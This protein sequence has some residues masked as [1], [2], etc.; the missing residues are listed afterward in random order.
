MPEVT[1][2]RI[3]PRFVERIWGTTQLAPWFENA[4]RRIGEVWFQTDPPLSLLTKFI[5]TSERLSVQ[6]HPND[7]QARA[8]GLD[9][10]KTEM[11]HILHAEPG[12]TVAL[13]FHEPVTLD[14]VEA[15]ART[16]AIEGM[17][18]WVSV[19]AGDT[20]YTPAGTVH[21]LGAGL[22]VV[23]VQQNSDTT[24]R[25][26]DYNRGRE[27]HLADGLAV[28]DLGP[29]RF[30][31]TQPAPAQDSAVTELVASDYFVTEALTL[32]AEYAQPAVES[33]YRLLIIL[34]GNGHIGQ[35][36]YRAGEVW[37]LNQGAEECRI[38][39]SGRTRILRTGPPVAG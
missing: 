22:V 38:V 33:G 26:W 13:G 1:P 34:E 7:E 15:A 28:S 37:L 19:S 31:P 16:G 3:E 25:L 32:D 8:R 23:E 5:F 12:A 14:V 17:L 30:R 18:D 27:L 20:I 35:D 6:V 11:W 9:N 36:P 24:Y 2:L 10:G 29:A 39:P 4:D 21:A